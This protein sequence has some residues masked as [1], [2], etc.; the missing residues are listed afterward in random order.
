MEAVPHGQ[1]DDIFKDRNVALTAA[2]IEIL[3]KDIYVSDALRINDKIVYDA[4]KEIYK[5][6][7]DNQP[8]DK[9]KL[10]PLAQI[11]WELYQA[12]I[13]SW[14]AILSDKKIG[15]IFLRMMLSIKNMTGGGIGEFGYLNYLKNNFVPNNPADTF[16]IEDKDGNKIIKK[17]EN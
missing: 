5:I 17:F 2:D 16:I 13:E 1:F 14:R 4:Y 6:H 3:V 7:E 12:K 11:L 15:Q 9:F 8:V 10:S